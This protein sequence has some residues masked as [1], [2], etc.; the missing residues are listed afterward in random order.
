PRLTNPS[1]SFPISE[2]AGIYRHPGYGTIELCNVSAIKPPSE[3][4]RHLLSDIP[5]TLPDV[6]DPLVPTLVAKW[7][8][9]EVT[10]IS[11][12]HFE[13]NVYNAT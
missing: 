13:H 2:L 3:S 4:C 5:A 10:H 6:L 12:A 11:L 1:P 8:G 9:V 7:R